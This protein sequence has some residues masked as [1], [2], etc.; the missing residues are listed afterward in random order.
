MAPRLRYAELIPGGIAPLRSLGHYLTIGTALEPVLLELVRLRASLLNGCDYC[1]HL[2][3]AE[4]HKHNEPQSRIDAL[5][6][7]QPT[8]AFTARE[9]A[10]LLWTDSL[11]DI[12][13]GH[14]SDQDFLAVSEFFQGKD[15][16]DLTL[17]I[18]AIN[19]GNR[20][21]I[22][23]RDEWKPARPTSNTGS[24]SSSSSIA[25]ETRTVVG[26]DGGK[27]AEE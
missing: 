1:T 3:T 15:L 11:T 23:F 2:H 25:D 16:A 21:S 26:D 4:L 6:D 17:A 10:A 22:A 9:R 5:S 27:V 24:D 18:A 20:M 8:D 12:Q 19:Q 13:Q 14:A 7:W